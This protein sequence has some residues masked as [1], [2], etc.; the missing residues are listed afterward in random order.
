[1]P[2]DYA[3]VRTC[4]DTEDRPGDR[5]LERALG[6]GLSELSPAERRGSLPNVTGH[7]AE[8]VVELILVEL[9]FAPIWHFAGPKSGGHGIDLAF[10]NPENADLLVVEVKGTF[11]NG[12]WPLPASGPLEELTAEWLDK[13]DNPGMH[14]W[15]LT[16]ADV[17]AA[18]FSL[19]FAELAMR[20][21]V[22]DSMS[23]RALTSLDDLVSRVPRPLETQKEE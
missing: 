22:F 17:R 3:L 4:L 11:R 20:V 23:F 16:S 21:V 2:L 15:N 5:L 1:L 14:N 13:D 9:G 6:E 10:L 19:N 7:L 12:R 8:S 18:L